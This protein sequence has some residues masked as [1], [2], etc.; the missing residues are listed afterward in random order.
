MLGSTESAS[1][2]WYVEVAYDCIALESSSGPILHNDDI[3]HKYTTLKNI[4]FL[5]TLVTR[6]EQIPPKMTSPLLTKHGPKI[7]QNSPS[8]KIRP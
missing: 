4:R 5:A 7:L 6:L 3:V 2:E 1:E 8:L